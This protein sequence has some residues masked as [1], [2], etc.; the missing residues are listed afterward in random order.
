MSAWQSLFD[1]LQ[2]FDTGVLRLIHAHTSV[3]LDRLMIFWS[4][5]KVWFPFYALLLA[6]WYLKEGK[7]KTLP[8]L[9]IILSAV[10]MSDQLASSVL[11]PLTGRLR[12][13]HEPALLA[14]L[15]L[16]EGCGGKFGFVS[17]HAANSIALSLCVLR[18]FP[19][20]KLLFVLLLCWSILTAYS[21]MYLGAHYPTD[22]LAGWL[23]GGAASFL[24]IWMVNRVRGFFK[25]NLF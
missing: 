6:F 4:D 1:F 23:T 2:P 10:I 19:K 7:S 8:A 3:W 20:Q 21:R 22:I 12:P 9:L 5:R 18:L 14:W 17:S 25:G 13:C 11:K 24:S 15:H 16:P